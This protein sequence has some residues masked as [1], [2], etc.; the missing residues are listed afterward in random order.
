MKVFFDNVF[1]S[2]SIRNFKLYF[3]AQ[4]VSLSGT[5]MQGIALSWLAYEIT[6]SATS[7]GVAL[8]LQYFPLL[9]FGIFGGLLID[10]LPKYSTLYITQF[11][12][13]IVPLI[14][15]YILFVDGLSGLSVWWLYGA[16]F[17]QGIIRIVDNPLRQ[18]FISQIV[19]REE[20]KNAI[21]LNSTSSYSARVLGPVLAGFVLASFGAGWCFFLNGLSFWFVLFMLHLMDKSEFV[22]HY[23]KKASKNLKLVESLQYVWEKRIIRDTLFIGVLLGTFILT[24]QTIFPIFAKAVFGQ[25]V[26]GFS[27]MMSAYGLGSV[28]GG[29]YTA[30]DKKI[31]QEKIRKLSIL[32]GSVYCL[33]AVSPNFISFL[34]LIFIVGFFTI[35]TTATANTLV[36]MQTSVNHIGITAA[37]WSMAT[38]GMSA[39]G[40]LYIGTVSDIFGPRVAVFCGG[41]LFLLPVLIWYKKRSTINRL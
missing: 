41:I 19:P 1:S 39:V 34:V 9:L 22:L 37:T 30:Q 2:L 6:G 24:F 14:I 7:L 12:F 5:W 32:L 4:I 10:K 38:I 36:R 31:S 29:L 21:A 40:S 27:Y 17:W 20:I 13:S 35:Q 33:L 26:N 15:T 18:S 16:S 25:N 11:L 28:F 3:I 8:S 23:D